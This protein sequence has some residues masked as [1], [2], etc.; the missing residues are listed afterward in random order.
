MFSILPISM[1]SNLLIISRYN[2]CFD[3]LCCFDII[4]FVGQIIEIINKYS[5]T[6]PELLS[7]AFALSLKTALQC[8]WD[9]SWFDPGR[10]QINFLLGSKLTRLPLIV[11]V[12]SSSLPTSSLVNSKPRLQ[13]MLGVVIS[14]MRPRAKPSCG[15][16][17]KRYR[18]LKRVIFLI[19]RNVHSKIPGNRSSR[20]DRTAALTDW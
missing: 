20:L 5:I 8:E 15:A 3:F 19:T 10:M 11:T 12:V 13:I 6:N 14:L 1:P 18:K 17:F 4:I 2:L 16:I 9:G 7:R